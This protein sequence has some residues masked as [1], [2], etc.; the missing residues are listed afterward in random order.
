[1]VMP[2]TARKVWWK[3]TEGHSWQASV[4][5]RQSNG[6]PYCSGRM[7]VKGQ[8]DL[9]TVSPEIAAEWDYGR[10]VQLHPEDLLPMSNRKVWWKCE[11]GHSYRAAPSERQNGNAC[12]KCRGHVQMRTM[13]IS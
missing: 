13:F 5:S 6:C 7:P 2:H 12:P 4:A 8:N 11:K 3:C 9:G 1:M 10:N